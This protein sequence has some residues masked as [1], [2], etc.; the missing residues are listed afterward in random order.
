M[1][2][3][4]LCDWP[5]LQ[6]PYAAALRAAV[7]YIFER[8]S[9]IGVLVTGTIIRGDPG[10]SSDL[11]LWI[12]QNKPYRQRVQKFFHGVPTEIFVNP[13]ERVERNFAEERAGARPVTAHMLATGYVIF[14]VGDVVAR[15]QQR[16]RDELDRP[17]VPS[18]AT[19]RHA[20]YGIATGLEDARDI[21]AIDPEMCASL[22]AQVVDDVVRYLYLRAGR[23]LPRSKELL[24]RL[25]DVDPD[26]AARSRRFYQA[27]ALDERLSLA[28][29]LVRRAI[30]EIGFFEWESDQEPVDLTQGPPP[31]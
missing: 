4:K 6:E 11:D 12:L 10:L 22:L 7:A 19:L 15:F 9:P 23:W 5:S 25:A 2:D 29:E 24:S 1:V 27:T 26:L 13:P 16:A 17:P 18:S 30:G 14:Q 31:A 21:A 20:R 8:F 3:L 28:T